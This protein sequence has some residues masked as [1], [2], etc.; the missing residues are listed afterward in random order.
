MRHAVLAAA[1][2]FGPHLS[3][4]RQPVRSLGRAVIRL[5]DRRRSAIDRRG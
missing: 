1:L 3:V 2:A 5:L 4:V